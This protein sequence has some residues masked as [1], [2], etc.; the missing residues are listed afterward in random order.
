MVHEK[1]VT[2][3]LMGVPPVPQRME[4]TVCQARERREGDAAQLLAE[5]SRALPVRGSKAGAQKAL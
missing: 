4:E 5:G 2:V 3:A 1:R